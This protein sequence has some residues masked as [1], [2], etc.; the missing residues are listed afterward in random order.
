MKQA[1]KKKPTKEDKMTSYDLAFRMGIRRTTEVLAE[2]SVID[3]Q[4]VAWLLEEKY[5]EKII[6]KDN[7]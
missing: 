3:W 6:K 2:E 4:V 7:D 5:L 1:V